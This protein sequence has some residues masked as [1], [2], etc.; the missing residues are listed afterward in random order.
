MKDVRPSDFC[1]TTDVALGQKN[2]ETPALNGN[3]FA[4]GYFFQCWTRA[5]EELHTGCRN[6]SD[7][8]QRRIAYAF[9]RCHLQVHNTVKLIHACAEMRM[10]QTFDT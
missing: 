5:L 3:L 10:L 2:L 9:A 6:L 4:P 1:V 8:T 7:E